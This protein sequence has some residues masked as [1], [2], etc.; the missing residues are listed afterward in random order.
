MSEEKVYVKCSSHRAR[1]S[2]LSMVPSATAHYD[3]DKLFSRTYDKGIYLIPRD[4]LEDARK[5]TGISLCRKQSGYN[6]CW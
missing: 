2:L 4:T 3:P 5:I 1:K 6:Q